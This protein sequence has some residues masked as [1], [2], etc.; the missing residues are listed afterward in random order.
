MLY[1]VIFGCHG[2][3]CHV[4][5]INAFF[6]KVHSNLENMQNRMFYL[7][8]RD[9]NTV[10]R[11]STA[12]GIDLVLIGIFISNILQS[13]KSLHDLHDRFQMHDSNSGLN[14]FDYFDLLFIITQS[15]H[16][17]LESSSCELSC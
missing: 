6:C 11:M 8:S 4:I 9:A 5:L 10:R 1:N 7:T 14:V 16:A 12:L 2:N 15:R 3:I 13:T 17:V